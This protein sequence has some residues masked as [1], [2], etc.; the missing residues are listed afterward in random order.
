MRTRCGCFPTHWGYDAH[1]MFPANL[2][3]PG[4][5]SRPPH[6]AGRQQEMDALAPMEADLREKLSPS[7]NLILYGPRGN[8]KTVLLDLF[9]GRLRQAGTAVVQATAKGAAASKEALA[10]ALA[11]N[12]GWR[13][14]LHRLSAQTGVS[15]SRLQLFGIGL[16][17]DSSEGPSLKQMLAARCAEQPLALLLDEAHVLDANLGGE[18]MDASQSVRRNGAPFLLVLAGTPGIQQVL[19]KMKV[20]H[21]E[22]SRRVPVGRLAPGQDRDA[23][24]KPLEGL[25]GSAEETAVAQLLEAANGYPYFLQELGNSAVAALNRNALRHID[26]AVA[27]QALSSFEPIKNAFYDHRVDELDDAGLLPHAIA[28]AQK[29]AGTDWLSRSELA[30]A[31][32]LSCGGKASEAD[33]RHTRQGL[34]ARGLVWIKDGGYE[35]GI[36]SLMAYLA[37][38]ARQKSPPPVMC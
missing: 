14:A 17:L 33:V 11:P 23:L 2:F 30:D 13:G 28:L 6:L 35:P 1:M 34:V 3:R 37:K 12:D 7:A 16:K 21:W 19:Q 8:G 36:P 5:G 22:R 24:M 25:G 4:D 10:A 26:A 18:L 27:E 38:S 29:F 20:S 32:A 15:P 31:L 9:G